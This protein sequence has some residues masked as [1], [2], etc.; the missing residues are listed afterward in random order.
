MS[1]LHVMPTDDIVDH[2]ASDDCVCGPEFELREGPAGQDM[3][4]AVHWS[5]DARERQEQRNPADGNDA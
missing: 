5:A 3:W 1:D 4:I 2:E